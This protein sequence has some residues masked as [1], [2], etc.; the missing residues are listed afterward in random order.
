MKER[1]HSA[2]VETDIRL[3][4]DLF[5]TR[6]CERSDCFDREFPI[7][8]ETSL[9]KLFGKNGKKAL[10]SI[11]LNETFQ[12][13]DLTSSSDLAKFYW[14]YFERLQNILG[15]Q[16]AK[17]VELKSFELMRNSLCENCPLANNPNLVSTDH[18]QVSEREME[19]RPFLYRM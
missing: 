10:D 15:N 12:S 19:T 13:A 5:D 8:L 1:G 4:V 7:C 14:E 3:N 16:V 6:P 18:K 17:V 2:S 9:L 11:I